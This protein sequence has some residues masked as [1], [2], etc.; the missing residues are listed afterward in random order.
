MTAFRLI[1]L[2]VHG[3]AELALGAMTLVAPFALGMGAGAIIV[4]VV[5]G[6]LIVG[7]ALSTLDDINLRVHTHHAY[8]YAMLGALASAAILLGAAGDRPAALYFAAATAVQ[9]ALNVTTRY[10]APR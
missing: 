9:L 6:A 5:I 4:A 8:D 3:A 1:S 7:L 10:S 2:P